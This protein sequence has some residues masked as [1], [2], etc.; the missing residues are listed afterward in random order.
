MFTSPLVGQ[1]GVADINLV[2]ELRTSVVLTGIDVSHLEALLPI[3]VQ[4]LARNLR[5]PVNQVSI[6]AMSSGATRALQAPEDDI[7][8]PAMAM[9]TLA[10]TTMLT[11][12]PAISS[13]SFVVSVNVTARQQSVVTSGMLAMS[14]DSTRFVSVFQTEA[15]AAAVKDPSLQEGV[16]ALSQVTAVVQTGVDVS[17]LPVLRAVTTTAALAQAP[18]DV[19][20]DNEEGGSVGIILAIVGSALVALGMAFAA[21][22]RKAGKKPKGDQHADFFNSHADHH[23]NHREE[24]HA[25]HDDFVSFHKVASP[26]L[27]TPVRSLPALPETPPPS[28]PSSPSPGCDDTVMKTPIPAPE[29]ESD[30]RGL[31]LDMDPHLRQRAVEAHPDWGTFSWAMRLTLC[32]TVGGDPGSRQRSDSGSAAEALANKRLR[33][34]AE[35]AAVSKSIKNDAIKIAAVTSDV[36]ML[37]NMRDKAA[38]SSPSMPSLTGGAAR[39]VDTAASRGLSTPSLG[40]KIVI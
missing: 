8:T 36:M 11:Y 34:Q 25:H 29:S 37:I 20:F 3:L 17:D 26:K 22:R 6:L 24:E 32:R 28:P 7:I 9:R 18:P 13:V 5:V 38:K 27:Q 12:A 4:A 16:S 31:V 40:R 19:Q 15:Q 2:R 1:T 30:A 23:D 33:L 21:V 14:A 39:D 35:E 10:P